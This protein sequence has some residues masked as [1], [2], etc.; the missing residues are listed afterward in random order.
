MKSPSPFLLTQ[1][2]T[3]FTPVKA[4]E[5]VNGG[6]TTTYTRAVYHNVRYSVTTDRKL[7]VVFY[8]V[9]GAIDYDS[10]LAEALIVPG[11]YTGLTPPKEGTE[12]HF[13][14]VSNI[15][16]RMADGHLHN[17]GIDAI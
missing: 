7:H 16:Y 6:Y 15:H 9:S 5:P 14:K 4:T 17:V 13:Y 10:I 11:V 3:V 8:D 12:K 1:S 2:V